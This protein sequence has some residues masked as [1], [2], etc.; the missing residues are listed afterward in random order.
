MQLTEEQRR[1]VRH[2]N[3]HAL[4]SAVAGSGKTTTMVARVQQLLERGCVPRDVLVLMFNRSA[5]DSF[6]DALNKRLDGTGLAVPD[7]RTYHSLGLRLVESFTRKGALPAYKLVT[8]DRIREKLA[9]QTLNSAYKEENGDHAW[10]TKED[11]EEFLRFIDLVKAGIVTPEKCF[12]QENIAGKCSYFVEA[13]KRFEQ[14][15]CSQRIRFYEDLVHEPLM[16]MLQDTHLATWVSNRVEHI[17][18]D[19][20]QDINEVQQQLLKILA[21]RRAKVMVVGDVDQCIYEWRGARPEYIINR[22][23]HDF[24]APSRYLLSYTFRY[25]HR[26]SLAANHLISRNHLR[27]RK[28]CISAPTNFDTRITLHEEADTHPILKIMEDWLDRG[29]GLD[30]AAVLVRLFGMSVPLELALLDAD[31]PYHLQG[32]EQV[33]ECREIKALIGYLKLCSGKLE[34]EDYQARTD[35]LT[36]MLSQPHLGVRQEEIEKLAAEIAVNPGEAPTRILWQ[37]HSDMPAFI[38]KKIAQ[39]SDDWEWLMRRS[40]AGRADL[41]LTEIISR[42]DL[43]DFFSKFSSRQA[44]AENR[45]ET[46]RS[47]VDFAARQKLMTD[48]FLGKLELLRNR[49]GSR[50]G[51][52]LLITSVHRAKGLEWPLVVIPGLKDGSFPFVAGAGE[53]AVENLE[54]ERRLFYVAVT[55]G[56]EKVALIHPPDAMLKTRADQGIGSAP[57]DIRQA[58]RFLF[59]ANLGLSERVGE[60]LMNSTPSGGAGSTLTAVNIEIANDYLQAVNACIAPIKQ[61]GEK[62]RIEP[63]RKQ[64]TLRV[65]DLEKGVQVHHRVFGDGT[66]VEVLGRSQGRIRVRFEQHGEKTLILSF[67]PLTLRR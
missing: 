62:S 45:I 41:L 34:Q 36:A 59:E 46:C 52:S 51:G 23:Q 48:E 42:L 40:V 27:D 47:F 35:Y 31:I 15:R 11:L 4:V 10:A 37:M 18:V 19:E 17:I 6:A 13:F 63:E 9:K 66:I 49:S 38:K 43:Y 2:E 22:F 14:G 25:G 54:D 29:R 56:I 1:I 28:L 53:G 33:F 7:V 12:E 20:Y 64:H 24:P 58:S 8:D 16:A 67:A 39:T 57:V 3:G 60:L 44:T 50:V 26:V 21:G 65:A 30:D 61:V 55:R 5:R 32:H